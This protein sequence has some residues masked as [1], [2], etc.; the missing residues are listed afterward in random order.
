M[1]KKRPKQLRLM[2]VKEPHLERLGHAWAQKLR[3][4]YKDGVD[5]FHVV[6]FGAFLNNNSLC[7]LSICSLITVTENI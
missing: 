3:Q 4:T 6:I 1:R 7:V 2:K 5:V